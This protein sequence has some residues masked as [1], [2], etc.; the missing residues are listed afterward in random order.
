MDGKN[1]GN[2]LIRVCEFT[3]SDVNP[4]VN[5]S[6][7]YLRKVTIMRIILSEHAH[8]KKKDINPVVNVFPSYLRKVTIN[9]RGTGLGIHSKIGR[10]F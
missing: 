4:L 3:K 7:F 1:Y 9:E 6:P 2:H 5:V 8:L 10:G